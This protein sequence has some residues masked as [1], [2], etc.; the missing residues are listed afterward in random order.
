MASEN[1]MGRTP[2]NPFRRNSKI[3]RTPPNDRNEEPT[4]AGST[5]NGEFTDQ[6]NKAEEKS[7][8]I[9]ISGNFNKLGS[10]LKELEN[11]M[12]GQRHVNQ[13]MRDLLSSI[14]SL[15]N[16]AEKPQNQRKKL[17]AEKATQVFPTYKEINTPKRLRETSGTLPPTKKPKKAVEKVQPTTSESTITIKE[18]TREQHSAGEKWVDVVKKRKPIQKKIRTKP[19]AII[20][21]KKEGASYADILRK[22]K[23]DSG[24]EELGSNVTYI[25]KTM[26]GDL[27]I[28]LKNQADKKAESF[29]S[30]LEGAVGEMAVIQPKSH[31]VTIVCKDLDEITTPE[32]I[33]AALHKE[34]GIQNLEKISVKSMIK[35]RS[36]TQIALVCLRAQEAKAALKLGKIRIGWSIC[37]LREYSLIPRCFR[38]FNLGHMARKCCNPTDRSSLCTRCGTGGHVAKICTNAPKC[39]LCKGDHSILSTKCPK[40]LEMMTSLKK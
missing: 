11:M 33:C 1:S 12:A 34:C 35:T 28:E 32:E 3:L 14:M 36:G 6:A 23:S 15:Y 40:Y 19:D 17:M 7:E 38:C 39:M 24:L 5:C 8:N 20:I 27:L 31:N 25:R 26:K 13:A 30:V 18:N 2:E 4:A 22:I 10:K 21:T 9:E 37:R 16:R 29:Q